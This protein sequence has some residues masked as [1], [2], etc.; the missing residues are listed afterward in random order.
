MRLFGAVAVTFIA[1][2]GIRMLAAF[3]SVTIAFRGWGEGGFAEYARL[4][5]AWFICPGI[6]AFF[7]PQVANH[8]IE[9]VN[10]HEVMVS[11]ITLAL[12]ICG[13][14]FL[15]AL[16]TFSDGRGGSVGE[17]FQFAF[18][19]ASILVGAFLAKAGFERPGAETSSTQG[20]G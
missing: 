13:G 19:S 11:F 16:V 14:M 15:L 1:F 10:M 2:L 18:Q 9:R 12:V 7:G 4:G 20:E 8:F 3:L 17:L 5:V 6:G